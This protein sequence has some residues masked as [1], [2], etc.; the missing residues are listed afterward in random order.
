MLRFCRP[1][2]SL[3]FPVDPIEQVAAAVAVGLYLRGI[4]PLAIEELAAS[5]A[6]ALHLSLS[7]AQ[8]RPQRHP[9][10]SSSSGWAIS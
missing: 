9:E 8:P 2:P 4:R 5:A 7:L 1:P 3:S 10:R 6:I